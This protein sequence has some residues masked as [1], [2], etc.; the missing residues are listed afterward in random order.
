MGERINP[1]DHY[2]GVELLHGW[3]VTNEGGGEGRRGILNWTQRE[4]MEIE[5]DRLQL[6][7]DLMNALDRKVQP[8]LNDSC[9]ST[10]QVFDASAL[11]ALH[12]GTCEDD[13][14]QMAVSDGEYEMYGVKECQEALA[15][16]SNV[17]H[18]IKSGTDF[19]PRLA[20]RFMEKIKKAVK[21]GIWDDLCFDWFVLVGHYRVTKK[22]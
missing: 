9:L 16:I 17:H 1:G 10:L 11:L 6:A 7:T 14:L 5:G 8:V 12:C 3:L 18:I 19:D 13:T 4:E 22:H 21:I 15:V 20:F 2:Q